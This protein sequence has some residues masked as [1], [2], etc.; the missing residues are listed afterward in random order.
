[1]TVAFRANS[2]AAR[3]ASALRP[4]Y[5]I[6]HMDN[7]THDRAVTMRRAYHY[8]F[9]QI[10][11]TAERWHWHV[12]GSAY[13]PDEIDP[14]EARRFQTFWRQRLFADAAPLQRCGFVYIPLQGRLTERRSFQAAS[15]V[16]MVKAALSYD[17]E[18]LVIATFHPKEVYSAAE[19]QAIHDLAAQNPRLSVQTG[20]M[21]NLLPKCDYIVTQNSSAA[22]NGLLF[23][24]PILL[25]AR[26]DFHHIAANVHKLGVAGAFQAVQHMT[27]DSATYLWWFWQKM[28]INAGRPEAEDQIRASLQRAGWPV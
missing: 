25:F 17:P 1:M 28:S 12:A 15:P 26:S 9:W 8:P 3:L 7:P 27:P 4:G 18:R 22:F 6:F 16:D 20:G 19:R 5:A 14:V 24:K 2:A 11:T 21:E 10:E 13:V 23:D